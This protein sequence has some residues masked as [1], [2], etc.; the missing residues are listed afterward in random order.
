[1]ESFDPNSRREQRNFGLAIGAVLAVIGLVHWGLEWRGA[2]NM[3]PLPYAWVASG[4]LFA[5]GGLVWP[6]LLKPLYHAWMVM[7]L[8]INWVVTR[9]VLSLI[10]Y[11]VLLPTALLMRVVSK[12]PLDRDWDPHAGTYLQPAEPQP[13][14]VESYK[15]QF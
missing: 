7:A 13:E 15:R 10:F 4:A 6:A 3:P 2:E 9:I 11:V 12:D 14:D 1:M 8:A 5:L